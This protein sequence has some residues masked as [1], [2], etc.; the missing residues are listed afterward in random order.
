MKKQTKEKKIQTNSKAIV[1]TLIFSIL[2]LFV[3]GFALALPGA[4]AI[5][6]ISNS[7]G[8]NS[9][10]GFF[11]ISGGY[12]STINLT[13]DF[14]NTRWKAFIGSVTGKFTLDDAGGSTIFDWTLSSTTGRV[15]ATRDSGSIEW[16]SIDCSDTTDLEAENVLL[17]HN[18]S[19][20][21]ITRTF[22]GTTHNAFFA[23]GKFISANTC[24][25]LNT[26]KNNA[27][28]DTDFE[29]MAMKDGTSTI[30]ATIL[31]NNVAGYNGAPYDFQMLVPE[32]GSS[33][34]TGAI[35]YYLYV[36]LD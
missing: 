2:I 27:S 30:Y 7:T 16:T 36:E 24:P 12:I 31:E 18:S 33:S 19:S 23:A 5:N 11:N 9:N 25:T 26:Y 35:A 21:N 28:Q 13:A 6:S 32:N 14:Q 4:P 15:Y 34:W 8:T 1:L 3:I 10:T 22:N 20:D 29:E 17:A